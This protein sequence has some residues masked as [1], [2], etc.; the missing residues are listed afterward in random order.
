MHDCSVVMNAAGE[1]AATK[2][3]K[4]NVGAGKGPHFS[5]DHFQ[6]LRTFHL[7]LYWIINP[8]FAG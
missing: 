6:T 3:T 5:L 1:A 4:S 2:N 7:H 8:E